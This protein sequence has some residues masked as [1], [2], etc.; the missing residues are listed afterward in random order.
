[1]NHIYILTLFIDISLHFTYK[2]ILQK[3]RIINR[4]DCVDIF[5]YCKQ[6]DGIY[7]D[8]ETFIFVKSI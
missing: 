8:K 2:I 1:M 5:H 4:K 6:L 3:F 7:F